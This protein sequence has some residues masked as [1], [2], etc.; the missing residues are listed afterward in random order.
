MKKK[1]FIGIAIFFVATIVG[2]Y[3]VLRSS[4][5]TNKIR[6]LAE[7]TIQDLLKRE[8]SIGSITGDPFSNLIINDVAV[9]GNDVLGTGDLIDIQTIEIKYSPTKLFG[10]KFI[11]NDLKIIQPRILLEIDEKGKLNLPEFAQSQPNKEKGE[12]RFKFF[13]SK[14]EIQSGQVILIDKRDSVNLTINNLNGVINGND[15]GGIFYNGEIKADQGSVKFQKITKQISDISLSFETTGNKVNLPDFGLKIG[16]SLVRGS[17]EIV[18]DKTQKIDININSKLALNDFKDFA[19]Q[20]KRLDGLV[21]ININA[22]LSGQNDGETPNISGICKLDSDEILINKLTVGKTYGEVKF[23]TKSFDLKDMI[24]NIGKGQAKVNASAQLSGGKISGYKG[25]LNINNFDAANIISGLTETDS[26]MTA[27]LD[28]NIKI[29]GKELR[30]GSINVDGKINLNNTKLKIPQTQAKSNPPLSPFAKGGELD[31]NFAKGGE[32]TEVA[33]SPSKYKEI[34][35]GDIKSSLNIDG[36]KIG[37]SVHRDKIAMDLK[38]YLNDDASLKLTMN[39]TGIDMAEITSIATGNPIINGQGQVSADA[40]MKIA[41]PAFLASMGLKDNGQRGHLIKDIAD[42]KGNVKIAIPSLDIPLANKKS[43]EQSQAHIGSLNGNLTINDDN[44]KT[45]DLILNLEG[46]KCLIQADVK[47]EKTPKINAKLILDSIMIE[48]YKSLIGENIPIYGGLIDGEVNVSGAMDSLNGNGEI[49]IHSLSIGNRAIDPIA[50]PITIQSNALSGQNELKIP[51]LLISSVG[52]QIKTAIEFSQSGDYNIQV[53]SSPISIARLYSDFLSVKGGEIAHLVPPSNGRTEDSEGKK[54]LTPGGDIQLFFSGKGNIKS[55]LLNGR[56]ELNDMSYNAEHFGNGECLINIGNDKADVK[57][58]LLDR[59]VVAGVN[60]SIRKPFPFSATLQL[61]DMNI[62]P[63]LRI[64]K[65]GEILDLRLTGD[66]MAN[67]DGENPMDISIDGS[68]ENIILNAGQHNWVNRLPINLELKN[69]K[70]NLDSLQM[71]SK[72]GNI[73]ISASAELSGSKGNLSGQNDQK[74]DM[75]V[76]AKMSD[77]DL[78]VVSDIMNSKPLKG[79]LDFDATIN[80]DLNSPNISAKIDGSEI[81]YDQINIDGFSSDITYGNNLLEV[82]RFF[83]KAFNGE[84]NLTYSMPLDLKDKDAFL[85]QKLMDKNMRL[86]LDAKDMDIGILTKLVP[87]V[88]SSQGKV[89]S[90]HIDVT[91]RI[92]QPR[93]NGMVSLKDGFIKLKSLPVPIDKINGQVSIQN[94]K[95]ALGE[96]MYEL[97]DS[98]YET[99]LGFSL[100]LDKGE[101]NAKGNIKISRDF[102]T[103]ILG[104]KTDKTPVEYL[105]SIIKNPDESIKYPSIDLN[106]S[107]ND[108]NADTWIKSAKNTSLVPPSNGRTELPIS[109]NLSVKANIQGVIYNPSGEIIISPIDLMVNSHEIKNFSLDRMTG[110]ARITL[111]DRKLNIS[112]FKLSTKSP[113]GLNGKELDGTINISGNLDINEKTLDLTCFGE[114]L[115]PGIASFLLVKQSSND[116]VNNIIKSNPPF[117]PLAK[118]G[119]LTEGFKPTIDQGDIGFNIGIKGKLD[120]PKIDISVNGKDLSMPVLVY[121][122]DSA[123]VTAQTKAA[124]VDKLIFLDRMTCDLSYDNGIFDI[125]SVNLNSYGNT[126]DVKGKLPVDISFLPAKVTFPD[127]DMDIKLLMDNFSMAFISQFV[128]VIQ[129]FNGD[130]KADI[131]LLGKVKDPKLI[132]SLK[133]QNADC[134]ISFRRVTEEQIVA[135]KPIQTKSNPPF[136]PLAKGGELDVNNINLSVTMDGTKIVIDDASFKIGEGYYKANGKL[137]MGAKLELQAFDVSFKVDPAILNPFVELAGG[138]IASKLSGSVKAQGKLTVDFRDIKGKPI[139]EILKLI[140]GNVDIEPEGINVLAANHKISNPK[141]IYAEL[142]KGRLNLPSFKIV[143]TTP[144][145]VN[146]T[147][148]SALGVWEIGGEKS[149]DLTA[150]VDMGFLSEFLNKP[151]SMQG[152]FGFKLEARGNEIKCFWPPTED[153]RSLKFTFENASVDRLEGKLAFKNQNL[154]IEKIWLALGDNIVS[155][156]GSVPINGKPMSV[157]IDAKLNDMNILSLVDKNVAESGGKGIVGATITG[158]IK[159][160]IANEEPVKFVGSC[161]FDNLSANFERSYVEFKDIKA[162][163]DFDSKSTPSI[164]FREMRGKLNDGEFVLDT[165]RKP[166]IEILWDKQKGYRIGEFMNIAVNVRDCL[167]YQPDKQGNLMYSIIFDADPVRLKGNVDA[168]KI[169]GNMTIK[170]GQYVETIQSLIQNLLSSRE[171]GSKASLDYPLVKNLELD[172]DV[173]RGSMKMNN[174]LVNADTEFTARVTGSPADP[175]VRANGR[176]IE[177]SSFKY[178]N[179]DFKITKGEFSNESKIDPK[180][181]IVAETELTQDQNTGIDVSQGSNLKIQMEVKGSLTERYPLVF[182]VLGGG[183]ALQQLPDLS[184]NQ[185]AIL[186]ATG[187]TSEQFLSRTIST[188]SPLLFEPARLYAE[189]LAERIHWKEYWL[190]DLRLQADPRNPKKARAMAAVTIMEQISLTIDMSMRRQWYGLQREVG[191]NFAVAGKVSQEGDWGFDLKLKRDFK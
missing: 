70:F 31:V 129:S 76:N 8:V 9:A 179:R 164:I 53:S 91:G 182:K 69:R 96:D 186:L 136:P 23:S 81:A 159:K 149:F 2:G 40:T 83:M 113:K 109:G 93:I 4:F 118:G 127:K 162:N 56:I 153:D 101:C 86:S 20:L 120:S 1:I 52:E 92:K 169:T 139:T 173:V 17:G 94:S 174:G 117:P 187:S 22:N 140:L 124:K 99:A 176:I 64:A 34:T 82:Q 43:D 190:K 11:V 103:N 55:P 87:E 131:S 108:I 89:D 184:Q 154:S 68:L 148:I 74:I 133:L 79:K 95:I 106:I 119:E 7:S 60:A 19:P 33:N 29:N 12:S 90:V 114:H 51:E 183:P 175:R 50:I 157:Q 27:Y 181:D 115:H 98:E 97:S 48:K 166:G 36:K 26:P 45:D 180:Y 167:I 116:E 160:I 77:F 185:I 152:R 172:I 128:D 46:S 84:A 104:T 30:P 59:T 54:D 47:A 144:G 158:D 32:L 15:I 102:V 161:V 24:I 150:F 137:E 35:I 111:A 57:I 165:S 112:D 72:D 141:R 155:I 189:S 78:S 13:L 107:A 105:I 14:A 132:G 156:S 44:I 58:R 147:S 6:S 75:N 188:S 18:S 138:Q 168:P 171:I 66:I 67:G 123:G 178:L 49:F 121:K 88:E 135:K 5:A 65:V 151:G 3:F 42:L 16:Q 10:L 62:E 110:L 146:G 71:D 85:P 170:E 38:G 25:D 63:A 145:V 37:M 61:E 21:N 143:D 28:G 80:G 122:Q 126:M 125:K 134:R 73:L 142:K 100:K 191:K 177:G 163:I 41:N 39:L 130:A